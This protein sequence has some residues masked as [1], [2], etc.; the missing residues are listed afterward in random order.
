MEVKLTPGSE[1]SISI[2]IC[3]I[4]SVKNILPQ[5]QHVSVEQYSLGAQ[6]LLI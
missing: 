4:D 5:S 3:L 6:Q 1:C 2:V